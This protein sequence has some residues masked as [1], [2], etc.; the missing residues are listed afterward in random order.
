[1][2]TLTIYALFFDDIRMIAFTRKDDDYFFTVT[3]LAL[4]FF[5]FEIILA[6]YSN[7]DD[8]WLSF[9]FWL[10]VVSTLSLIPDI[11]W[12]MDGITG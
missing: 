8:Y 3:S 4:F 5:S 6:S 2:T 11:G 12:I 1:M 9:F 7:K 10:D